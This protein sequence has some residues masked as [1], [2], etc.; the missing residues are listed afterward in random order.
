[1][2]SV[3]MLLPF[4]SVALLESH[5]YRI[6]WDIGILVV[7]YVHYTKVHFYYLFTNFEGTIHIHV[8]I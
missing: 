8:Y 2:T 6:T 5:N 1:M 3:L 7:Q 4:L